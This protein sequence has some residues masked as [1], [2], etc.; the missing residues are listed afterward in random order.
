MSSEV[1]VAAGLA[2]G[3]G[4]NVKEGEAR[5][6]LEGARPQMTRQLELPF[7][8]RGEAPRDGRSVEAP[9]AAKGSGHPGNDSDG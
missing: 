3:E 1:V 4:P 7:M 2:G 9:T 8:S 5:L 6:S